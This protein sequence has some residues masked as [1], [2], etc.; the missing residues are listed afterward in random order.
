MFG[1]GIFYRKKYVVV[2]FPVVFKVIMEFTKHDED[3]KDDEDIEDYEDIEDDVVLPRD[4]S[5]KTREM[6]TL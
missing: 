2:D 5:C 1:T 3:I 4:F 6:N